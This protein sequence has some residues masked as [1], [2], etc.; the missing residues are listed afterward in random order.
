MRR[1]EFFRVDA[2]L[3][4]QLGAS[5]IS[6]D[7]QCLVELIKNAYDA[8]AMSAKIIIE[9]PG[10]IVVE[11]DGNGMD[12]ETV[13]RGWLTISNSLKM[14]QKRL[15]VLTPQHRRTP[16]GDKGLG[17]LSTQRLG[18]HLRIE[19]VAKDTNRC[20]TVD[21]DWTAFMP[22]SDLTSVPVTFNEEP[23]GSRKHGTKIII[24][25]LVN[26][27]EWEK[28]QP[29]TLRLSLAALV[30]PY[31]E[32]A[33]FR[34][35]AFLNGVEVSPS[36][37]AANVRRAALQSYK[38]TFDGEALIVSGSLRP[39]T[40]KVNTTKAREDFANYFAADDG[41]AFLNYL[42][43]G[44]KS[45]A[46]GLGEGQDGAFVTFSSRRKFNDIV[47]NSRADNPGPF[48]GEVDSFSLDAQASEIIEGTPALSSSAEA[49][50]LVKDLSG[51]RV[52]R[53]GFVIR[54]AHDWLKLG[55]NQ[56]S[57]GSFYGLRPFNT[58]GYVSI[59]ASKNALVRE[60]TDREGF[61]EDSFFRGFFTL[62]DSFVRT[63][64]D[65]LEHLRRSW[66]L[67]VKEQESARHELPTR[68]PQVI[69]RR[70][71]ES[72]TKVGDAKQALQKA[73]D[74]ISESTTASSQSLFQQ[75][76]NSLAKLNDAQELLVQ[77]SQVLD[78]VSERGGLAGILVA[79]LDAL[80]AKLGEVYELVSLGITAEALSH[81][82]SII[83]ERVSVETNTIQKHAKTANLTDLKILRFFE[84]I[85][86]TVSALEKQLGH[87]D[88]A[89][90]Y[91]REKREIFN[92]SR[93]IDEASSYYRERFTKSHIDLTILCPVDFAVSMN[94]G[95]LIQILDNLVLN[96]EYWVKTSRPGSETPGQIRL[97]IVSPQIVIDDSGRGVEQAFEETLFDPFITSKPKGEGRGLGL[98]IATQLLELD[99]CSLK[100]LPERNEFGR[101]FRIAVGLEGVLHRA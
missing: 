78:E 56:T 99:G 76:P 36:L 18:N 82:I 52:Y 38:L 19:S 75:D 25:N 30:S 21:I 37:V 54:T 100:L 91:A 92:V 67:Y 43:T 31:E 87:L 96:S 9:S 59:S 32:V 3:M 46:Y 34:L 73:S 26:P 62:L 14:E 89:L 88:P 42:L 16:L 6:D 47:G 23:S 29:E 27:D 71:R 63:V 101:R 7:L 5:L 86:A 65:A 15:G 10:R 77:A 11:D 84:V 57:G 53:D 70:L 4:Q 40:F 13:K 61:I 49:K 22:G 17:R 74:A 2:S 68:D 1:E 66:N 44:S 93:L 81:D 45:S 55:E 80:N 79:E 95:K 97:E 85:R 98:F 90:R 35:Q 41:K 28:L 48:L 72:F 39:Q 24:T 83:L 51:I 60:T 64:N 8:D 58:M 69:E 94:K 33:S 12:E 20:L 50:Q